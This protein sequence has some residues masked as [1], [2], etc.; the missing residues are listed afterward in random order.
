MDRQADW[1]W[2]R[3]SGF[4]SWVLNLALCRLSKYFYLICEPQRLRVTRNVL[5]LFPTDG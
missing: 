3:Y 4:T 5:L 1:Y 2:V